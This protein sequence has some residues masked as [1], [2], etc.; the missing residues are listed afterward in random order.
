MKTN[1]L[2]I[3]FLSVFNINIVLAQNKSYSI[4]NYSNGNE[5][6]AISIS[7]SYIFTGTSNGVYQRNYNGEIKNIHNTE[8]GLLNNL[9]TEIFVEDENKVW[10]ATSGG[11]HLYDGD[12]YLVFDKNSG[13]LNNQI[14]SICSDSKGNIWTANLAGLSQFKDKKWFNYTIPFVSNDTIS[15]N[16]IVSNSGLL[17]GATSGHGLYSFD[18]SNWK[19]Y[20]I[21]NGLPSNNIKC[22][23]TDTTGVLWIATTDKGLIEQKGGWVQHYNSILDKLV[24]ND[25]IIDK[26]NT[27]WIFTNQGVIKMNNNSW[28]IPDSLLN[29][30]AK[31]GRVDKE[32]NLWIITNNQLIKY[33]DSNNSLV[34]FKVSGLLDNGGISSIIVDDKDVKWISTLKGISKLDNDWTNIPTKE[35]DNTR[36]DAYNYIYVMKQDSTKNIWLSY[37]NPTIVSCFDGKLWKPY[38]PINSSLNVYGVTS[39]AIGRNNIIWTGT[40]GGGIQYFDGTKWKNPAATIRLISNYVNCIAVDKK[41]N[42]WVGTESNGI[43]KFDGISFINYGLGVNISSIAV[44]SENKIWVGT[45]NTD[46]K[47]LLMFDGNNW[48]TFKDNNGL[49]EKYVRTIAIDKSDNV[50]CGHQSKGLTMYNP[51]QNIWETFTTSDGLAHNQVTALAV[52]SKNYIYVGTPTGLSI[53]KPSVVTLNLLARQ[54]KFKSSDIVIDVPVSVGNFTKIKRIAFTLHYDKNILKFKKCNSGELYGLSMNDIDESDAMSGNISIDYDNKNISC[55][56]LGD[57]SKILNLSFDVLNSTID[58]SEVS[59]SGI[60]IENYKSDNLNYQVNSAKF[61]ISDWIT[62]INEIPKME[63]LNIIYP[64]PT[65]DLLTIESKEKIKGLVII[66]LTGKILKTINANN[67]NTVKLNIQ[68]LKKGI[69]ILRIINESGENSVKLVKK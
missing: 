58:S 56:S 18:E 44:D 15:F 48:K 8:K 17:W 22:L 34:R 19:V 37:W 31:K 6:Y 23:Q 9:V 5:I 52:D 1:L 24:I 62:D 4:N 13:L 32:N 33:I 43:S 20:N 51:R 47:G 60:V 50:W 35:I 7:N 68:D 25:F 42:V 36:N 54:S 64:N 41:N 10:F 66:D 53:L 39:I 55:Q 27:K 69:Y 12:N 67:G 21:S 57:G 63:K 29:L 45:N 3:A 40:Y 30:N 61:K 14:S 11:L 59:L 26:K 16:S 46:N 49:A 38:T 65:Q 28:S 2:F